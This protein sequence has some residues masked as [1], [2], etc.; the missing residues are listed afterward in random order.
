MRRPRRVVITIKV[1]ERVRRWLDKRA[2]EVVRKRPTLALIDARAVVL[3]Q[4]AR[5]TIRRKK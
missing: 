2:L 3:M 4:I 1:P 5:A